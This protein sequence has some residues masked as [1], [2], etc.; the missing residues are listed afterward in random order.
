MVGKPP[1]AGYKTLLP[2]SPKRRGHR[3]SVPTVALVAVVL[4]WAGYRYGHSQQVSGPL[5]SGT[6]LGSSSS[7]SAGIGTTQGAAALSLGRITLPAGS[8]HATTSARATAGLVPLDEARTL[9]FDL[10]NGFTNQRIALLSGLVLAAELNRSV[11]LPDFLLDGYQPDAKEWITVD[12]AQVEPFGVWFDQAAFVQALNEHGM[13]VA[14]GAAAEPA[15]VGIERYDSQSQPVDAIV[16]Y[17]K[18]RTRQHIRIACPAFRL[19]GALIERHKELL[20]AASRALR[21]SP[22]YAALIE[23]RRQRIA[24]LTGAPLGSYNVLHLRA[25]KD[26]L[27]LCEWWQKPE[28]GRD[29]CMNNTLTVGQPLQEHGFPPEVPV[30]VVTSFRDAVKDVL[31]AALQSIRGHKFVPVLGSELVRGKEE[32]ALSREQRALVDYYLGLDAQRFLGNS[33]STFTAFIMLERKWAHRPAGHYNGGNVP[34]SLF[35]PFYDEQSS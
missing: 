24:D 22:R 8:L 1:A 14:E 6:A 27:A 2:G 10:C 15:L 9:Q 11:V 3:V 23:A 31:D 12:K 18:K 17:M 13:Q 32:E 29:N 19:P 16:A 28:E 30:V 34:L 26:W 7:G 33:V 25:E 35:F 21:P 4:L 20:M 5:A